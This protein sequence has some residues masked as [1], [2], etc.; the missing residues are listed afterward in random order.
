MC[1]NQISDLNITVREFSAIFQGLSENPLLREL[2]VFKHSVLDS[3]R[4]FV[5]G[6]DRNGNLRITL[7]RHQLQCFT[8]TVLVN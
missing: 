4:G 7:I 2:H 6:L 8:C 1:T 5:G 3:A